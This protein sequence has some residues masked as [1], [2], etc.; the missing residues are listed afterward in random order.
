MADD[1]E[2]GLEALPSTCAVSNRTQGCQAWVRVL[3]SFR[4]TSRT[5]SLYSSHTS[6]FSEICYQTPEVI[7]QK[8]SGLWAKNWHR[9]FS[10]TAH[11]LGLRC[12]GGGH[13]TPPLHTQ[14]LL[15]LL[16]L[17]LTE[18]YRPLGLACC[19]LRD[20]CKSAPPYFRAGGSTQPSSR[21]PEPRPPFPRLS[22]LT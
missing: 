19:C 11:D 3:R 17:L 21:S 9:T 20:G 10:G 2:D 22:R 5:F 1:A 15:L 16:H 4:V 18:R 14:Q 6:R 12:L 8:N 7:A 13:E